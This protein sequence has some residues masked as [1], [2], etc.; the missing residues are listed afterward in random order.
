MLKYI[1]QGWTQ[2]HPDGVEGIALFCLNHTAEAFGSGKLTTEDI[3]LTQKLV[4][5]KYVR[6][7]GDLVWN[8]FIDSEKHS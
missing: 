1:W 3:E 7:R 6:C 4:Q 2:M 8:R 5:A